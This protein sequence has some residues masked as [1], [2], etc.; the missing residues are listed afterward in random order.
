M[1]EVAAVADRVRRFPRTAVSH[2]VTGLGRA[3]DT[4]IV[5]DTGGD[6]RMS[7]VRRGQRITVAAKVTTPRPGR[8]GAAGHVTIEPRDMRGPV[9]WLDRGTSPA[10]CCC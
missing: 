1:T 5:S 8:P 3:I 7:G 9:D 6:R 4:R 2:V 10:G